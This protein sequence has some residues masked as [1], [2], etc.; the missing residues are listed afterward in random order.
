MKRII[1]IL[2]IVLSCTLAWGIINPNFTPKHL[3]EESHLIVIG[4]LTGTKNPLEWTLTV[5]KQLKPADEK[6]KGKSEKKLTLSLADCKKKQLKDLQK[7]FT[8]NGKAQVVLYAGEREGEKCAYFHISGNW[9]NAK[10][11]GKEKWDILG[12]A[13]DMSATLAGGTD[14][15]IRMSEYLVTDPDGDVPVTAGVQWAESHLTVGKITGKTGGLSAALMGKKNKVCVFAASSEGDKIFEPTTVDFETTFKEAT[16]KYRLKSKSVC[17]TWMDVNN[18]GFADLVS[19]NGEKLSVQF[20]SSDGPLTAGPDTLSIPLERGCIALNPCRISGK[21]AVVVSTHMDPEIFVA[22]GKSWKQKMLPA[23]EG[24]FGEAVACIVADLNQ[25]GEVDILLP[26]SNSGMLRKGKDGFFQQPVETNVAT[27][28][29]TARIAVNDYNH[30]GSIDIFISGSRK[31]TLWENDGKGTFIEVFGFSG[32]MSYKCPAGAAD[33]KTLDMNQDGRPDLC[34]VYEDKNILYHFNRGFR[35]FGEEGEVTLPGLESKPGETLMGQVAFAVGD[36]NEDYA[37]DLIVLLPNGELFGYMNSLYELPG[38]RI[39]L[40]K[41]A[42]NAGPI[43]VS[44]WQGEDYLFCVGAGTVSGQAPGL[45]IPARMAGEVTVTW[46]VPGKKKMQEKKV[47][48][49]NKTIDVI[50]GGKK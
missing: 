47:A 30:D 36:F 2:V 22:E 34:L 12:H 9:L 18:D 29:G 23:G 31:N 43:T 24:E 19:F 33:V 44:C 3:C 48:V 26:G 11:G 14:M 13:G 41:D 37:D 50:I 17:F 8:K 27:F 6:K 39:R 21:P 10:E 40:S 20:G 35:C 45:Y 5:Q 28:G 15:L 46:A 25:D 4:T 38:M 1:G 32:S 16:E 42:E 7:T 49:E